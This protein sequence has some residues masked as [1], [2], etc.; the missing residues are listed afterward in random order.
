MNCLIIEDHPIVVDGL[1]LA[2]EPAHQI[3]HNAATAED[4]LVWLRTHSVDLIIMD[5]MMPGMG[6]Q[7]AVRR[8]RC[9]YTQ[10]QLLI[11]SA[12]CASPICGWL[13]EQGVVGLVDKNAGLNE[14]RQA[15]LHIERG[16]RYLSQA[17]AQSQVLGNPAGEGLTEREFQIVQLLLRGLKPQ[18]IA[19]HLFISPKT[20]STYRQRAMARLGIDSDVA[21]V[22]LAISRGWIEAVP[23]H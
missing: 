11:F 18:A 23:T 20:V 17:V 4:G 7:E 14:V 12:H 16:Q 19:D 5:M 22:Q 9:H 21:L 3:L 13:L 15:L 8:L 2:L 1:R 10:I 6:G